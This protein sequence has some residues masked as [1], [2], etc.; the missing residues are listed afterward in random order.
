MR[1]RITF[2]HQPANAIDPSALKVTDITIDG[3]KLQ[4]VREDKF[5][6]ALDELPG[7]VSSVL[8]D[9]H[10][11]HIRW[12][13]PKPY[14]TLDPLSSRLPPGFHVFYTPMSGGNTDL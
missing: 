8:R 1:Q 14:G 7:D 9:C 6:V 13:S 11:L 10:E 5:T 4:A 12:V 3:P 2:I